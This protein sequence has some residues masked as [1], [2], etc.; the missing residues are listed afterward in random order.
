M[1]SK[2]LS[3]RLGVSE[4][5]CDDVGRDGVEDLA[6]QGQHGVQ[7]GLLS[8]EEFIQVKCRIMTDNLPSQRWTGGRWAD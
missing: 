4:L 6:E 1:V 8:R 7:L 3:E 2:H 5:L